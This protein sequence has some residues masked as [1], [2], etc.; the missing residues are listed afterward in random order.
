MEALKR[1]P[2]PQLYTVGWITAL[3]KE[4][5][6]AQAM[7]DEE[8]QRPENFRKHP[9]DTNNYVWGRVGDHNIVIASLPAGKYGTVSAATTA[10]S[11]IGSLPHLRFGLMVGIGA[12]IPRLADNIDIRLGDVVVSQPTGTSPGVVQYDLGKLENDGQFKRVGSLASPPEVL[13]KGLGAL[14]AKRRLKGPQV[15]SILDDILQR[16][17]LLAEA[18]PGDAAF[19][20]QGA[21]NDRLF[22]ASSIHIQ[23]PGRQSAVSSAGAVPHNVST[24]YFQLAMAW[25]WSFFWLVYASVRTPASTNDARRSLP[26]E[27]ASCQEASQTKACEHCDT[28][29]EIGRRQRRSTDPVVHYGVIASG[30]SVV[31]DGISRDDI[32]QRLGDK[33]ICFEMEAADLMDNFPCLVIRGI[34]DYADTHKN[35]RWQNYAAATAAA[36]A[37]ELLEVIDGEDVEGASRIDKIMEELCEGV[38]QIASTTK[39]MQR[40]LHFQD[41][42]KWL[43]PPDPSANYN[44]AF[45][46]RHEGT[47]QWF[48]ESEE[49]SEWK[50]TPKSSLWLH[51]I[52]GC[53]KTILSSTVIRDLS[54]TESY[55][56]SLLYFYFDFTDTSKQS[57]E[58]AIRSLIAQLYSKSL[59]V[60]T[61]LD[62][63]YFSCKNA[64]RQPSIDSLISTFE[65]MAQQIG[66]VWIVLDALDECQTRA[67][68][69]YEGLLHWIVSVLNSPQANIH[70]LVTSRPEHDIESELKMF[71]DNRVFLQ[72]TLVTEDI[73]AYVHGTVRQ[74]KGFERWQRKETI[75]DEIESHLME[76]ANEMFRW[77]SCQLDALEKCP[78]PN[79]LRQTLRSLPRTLDETYA[80]LIS[81]IPPEFEQTARRLLQFL[82]FSERPLRIEE[83]VDMIAVVTEDKPRFDA[84]NR[85]PQ[86]YEIS[87]YCSSLV[88]VITRDDNDGES[89]VKELQLAHFSVKKYLLS[90][91]VEQAISGTF[92]ETLARASITEICLAYLLELE[93]SLSPARLRQSYPLAQYA[94]QYWMSHAVE[95]DTSRVDTLIREFCQRK[96]SSKTFYQLHDPDQPWIKE[97]GE[98]ETSD[99]PMLYYI[100]L[101]GITCAIEEMLKNG[102]DV[103]AEGG[104]Y[105]NALQAASYNGHKEIV[106]TLLD[107][108]ADVNAQG[109]HFGNA[110]QAASFEGHQAVVE[111]IIS[112]GKVDV[113]SRDGRDPLTVPIDKDFAANEIHEYGVNANSKDVEGA[114]PIIWAARGG[115]EDAVR[116]LLS[117][118]KLDPDSCDKNDRTTLSWANNMV[119]INSQDW[120]GYTPLMWAMRKSHLRVVKLLLQGGSRMSGTLKASLVSQAF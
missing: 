29:T 109:G 60:Q 65:A 103:N 108:G 12:G 80:R 54:N 111:T 32:V 113:D 62:S 63:L 50:K 4:L 82:V 13:L 98:F 37:K 118:A 101:R 119:D 42:M 104:E 9:K 53:G 30:N 99:A 112:T 11:M 81:K 88:A 21:H 74:Y 94:A 48:L 19:V 20:H 8:H 105:G 76:K 89:E 100:A 2:N 114:T 93:Y 44:K 36:F 26:S 107:K 86:P 87:I 58:K 24:H 27:D 43:S 3:D 97:L 45:Q 116:L 18:E 17:P 31:K 34:C 56:K 22:E 51:G 102:A 5:T 77:V 10:W 91:R 95:A 35:D 49:Y 115:H 120:D 90:D 67:N 55:A 57:L 23:R 47:G 52:P 28:G 68:P 78:D 92:R 46:Q 41:V 25:I 61:H 14:K 73:R 85:M 59:D 84:K 96:H 40:S 72:S 79:S 16:H 70:L 15:R 1:L 75:L 83:A 110:L 39:S 69:R 64:S 117:Q 7:L 6:A 106:Q 66:E 71:I 33:C 38:S